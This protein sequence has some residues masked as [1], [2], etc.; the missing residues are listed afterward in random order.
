MSKTKEQILKILES[1]DG[2]TTQE[3]ANKLERSPSGIRG[4]ISELRK[5]G[6]NIRS[7][8]KKYFLILTPKEKILNYVEKTRNYNKPIE[9]KSL[10]KILKLSEDEIRDGMYEIYKLGKLLQV[11]NDSAMILQNY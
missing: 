7:F 6:Y 11:T 3:L 8:N 10:S 9:Y 5:T 1:C 2:I 4:R